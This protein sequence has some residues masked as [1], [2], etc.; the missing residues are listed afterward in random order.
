MTNYVHFFFFWKILHFM[1][2]C[3]IL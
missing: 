1:R 2:W 3:N